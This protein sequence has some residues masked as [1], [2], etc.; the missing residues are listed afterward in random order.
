[1]DAALDSIIQARVRGTLFLS[2]AMDAYTEAWCNQELDLYLHEVVRTANNDNHAYQLVTKWIIKRLPS[3]DPQNPLRLDT[4]TFKQLCMMK[5]AIE[6][7]MYKA[8]S[9]PADIAEVNELTSI[10]SR[11]HSLIKDIGGKES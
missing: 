7:R 10:H 2:W 6:Y 9:V 4:F 11:L 8:L 3:I 5:K 1:M